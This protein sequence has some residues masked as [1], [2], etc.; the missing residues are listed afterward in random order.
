MGDIVNLRQARKRKARAEREAAAD[1]NRVA[2][3]RTKAE[4]NATRDET[5][6]SERRLDAHRLARDDLED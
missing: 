5:E 1:A 3:G 6:R 2:F 4:R